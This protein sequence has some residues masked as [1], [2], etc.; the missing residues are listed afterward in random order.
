MTV[1]HR[2]AV[3]QGHRLFYREA[4]QQS[5]PAVVL[6]HGYP[7]SSFMF[8]ELIPQLADEYRVIAPDHLGYGFSDAP[9]VEQFNYTFDALASLTSGLLQKLGVH[10][11]SMVV[12]GHGAEIGWRLA[13]EK[14]QAVQ[15][16]V[17]LSGNGD[18]AGFNPQF[19]QPVW[20][21]AKDPNPQT[22]AALRPVLDCHNIMWQY[23]H[24][25]P[26]ESIISPDTWQHDSA[27][28]ARPGNDQVQ[29]AL[30]R[31]YPNNFAVYDQLHQYLRETQVPL[32]A[33]WGEN[34]EIFSPVGAL[35]FQSHLADAEVHV[36]AGGH[37]MV[38]NNLGAVTE[39]MKSFLGHRRAVAGVALVAGIAA[40]P[41]AGA[42]AAAASAPSGAP[43][44]GHEA[45]VTQTVET[46]AKSGG[47]QQTNVPGND[48]LMPN[49]VPDPGTQSSI[50]LD[51]D[52][53]NNAHAIVDAANAMHLP[54]RAAVIAVATSMQETKL[55]NYGNLGN[56]NDHDSLG[57]FQQRP[58]SG[59]GS[60]DQLTDPHYAA[61]AFL[62][63]LVQV[64]N[65]DKIQLTDA[66]QT[67]Q[68]SAFGDRYAQ[69][70]KQASDLVLSTYHAGPY[71]G[72]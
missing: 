60:P 64:P 23:L 66:A 32:M 7:S 25:A 34:D 46:A 16:I 20:D 33:I 39:R 29:L 6:L 62:K 26:D 4:G 53:I 21:Y 3:V 19:W 58:S 44:G 38:E 49:G 35:A 30:F 71:A 51:K 22:E 42:S 31:D 41:I 57:L 17:T 24:G 56:T 70:E 50:N 9:P 63:Q 36:L 18:E 72:Q 61:T 48:Q 43:P 5:A 65:W 12:N 28:I 45:A 2:Y 59:W 69:W 8:R 11:Y 13:L 52:Q 47:A 55:H 40:G 15:A 1:H 10:E 67:V 37:F 14:P 27:Q 54:P 68:V